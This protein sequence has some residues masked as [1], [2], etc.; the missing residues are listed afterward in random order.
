MQVLKLETFDSWLRS[1]RDIEGRARILVRLKRV[2]EGNFGD[3][4]SVGEGVSE[5]RFD[6]GPGYRVYFAAPNELSIVLLCGGDK[7]SQERDIARAKRLAG[8]LAGGGQA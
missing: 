7:D 6:F 4:K 3:V 2:A 8:E 5:L 1:L